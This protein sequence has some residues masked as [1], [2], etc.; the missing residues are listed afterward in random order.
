MEVAEEKEE[1]K[2]GKVEKKSVSKG[3]VTKVHHSTIKAL[4]GS[5]SMLTSSVFF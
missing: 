2:E 5:G 1:R 4:R 3:T